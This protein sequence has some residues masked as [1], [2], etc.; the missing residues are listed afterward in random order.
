[1]NESNEIQVKVLSFNFILVGIYLSGSSF[2]KIAADVYL[3][4]T[5][6]HYLINNW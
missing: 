5:A 1:M 4:D 3:P 6:W 2:K